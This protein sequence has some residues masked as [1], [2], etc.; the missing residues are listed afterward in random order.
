[1]VDHWDWY[2]KIWKFIKFGS[3]KCNEKVGFIGYNRLYDGNGGRTV[4]LDKLQ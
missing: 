4:Y 3:I 1:M 2:A